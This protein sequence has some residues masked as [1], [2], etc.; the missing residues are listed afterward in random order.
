MVVPADGRPPG[1]STAARTA[2]TAAAMALTVNAAVNPPRFPFARLP[3]DPPD[4]TRP[5]VWAP[6]DGAQR[7]RRERDA[8]GQRA[9]PGGMLQA[10]RAEEEAGDEQTGGGQHVQPSSPAPK[11]IFDGQA[12]FEHDGCALFADRDDHSFG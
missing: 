11:S 1:T 10:E 3:A 7:D 6:I 5:A 12:R 4:G 8:G 2:A 9:V